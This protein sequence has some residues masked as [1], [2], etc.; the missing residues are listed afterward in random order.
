MLHIIPNWG[1]WR[2]HADS[3]NPEIKDKNS[4]NYDNPDAPVYLI[5]GPAGPLLHEFYGKASFVATQFI[6]SGLLDVVHS[7]GLSTIKIKA[8][9]LDGQIASDKDYFTINKTWSYSSLNY[10]YFKNSRHVWFM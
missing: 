7:K 10:Y 6:E 3:N 8:K 2:L 5:V 4:N 9:F 1:I